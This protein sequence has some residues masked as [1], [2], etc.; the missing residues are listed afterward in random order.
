MFSCVQA[1]RRI[2]P[3]L[4]AVAIEIAGGVV[5]YV[6]AGSPLS[7]AAGLGLGVRVTA[8]DVARLTAFYVE[9]GTAPRVNVSPLAHPD[10]VHL[11]AR[12]GYRPVEYENVLALDIAG[13]QCARDERIERCEDARA[14]GYASA[15]GFLGEAPTPEQA[16]VGTL[17]A[18]QPDVVA[19]AACEEGAAIATGAMEVSDGLVSMFAA[20]TLPAARGR[21]WQRRLIADRVA[22][23]RELGARFAGAAAAVASI[24]E[25][26][27]RRVGFD[28]LLTRAV[29][30]R[31]NP[32]ITPA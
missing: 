30:E 7:E 26:N 31:W 21:G 19:L 16:L 32:S 25:A 8:H 4:E 11:L 23:G 22:R 13:A 5:P 2:A 17:I 9:R 18:A 10:L 28:V 14:W 12:D 1:A 3:H 6:G 20:S 29:W 24:S 15:C 27:F